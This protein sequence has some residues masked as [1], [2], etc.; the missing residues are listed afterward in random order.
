MQLMHMLGPSRDAYVYHY[1]FNHFGLVAVVRVLFTT[2]RGCNTSYQ[3][4]ALMKPLQHL[5][6]N[7]RNL[8]GRVLSFLMST[9]NVTCNIEKEPLYEKKLNFVRGLNRVLT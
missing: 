5:R 2:N 1:S 3:S 6:Q 9:R 7:I 4:L 8:D